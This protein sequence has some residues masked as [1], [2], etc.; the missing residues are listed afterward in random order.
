MSLQQ[1]YANDADKEVGGVWLQYKH[2][3]EL[4]MRRAGGLNVHYE[5]TLQRKVAPHRRKLRNEEELSDDL[6][7]RLLAETYAET[8]ILDWRTRQADGT[9]V[10]TLEWDGAQHKYDKKLMVAILCKLP[11]FFNAVRSD[12]Q[13]RGHFTA[14]A[15]EGD[16]KN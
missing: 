4:L 14:E 11:D 1:A 12:A 2:G 13:S 7:D 5:K 10:D 16:A 6:S 9:H 15:K 8:I 3:V